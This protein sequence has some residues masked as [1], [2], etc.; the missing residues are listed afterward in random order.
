MADL[1]FP[2]PASH[3]DS[4][5]LNG[6]KYVYD[7]SANAWLTVLL[8]APLDTGNTSNTQI[9]FNDAGVANGSYGLTFDRQANTFR[10]NTAVISGNV[11][12]SFYN[13]DGSALTNLNLS[14]IYTLTNAAFNSANDTAN[15]SAGIA[16][17]LV[18]SNGDLLTQIYINSNTLVQEITNAIYVIANTAGNTAN[19]A[20]QVANTAGDTAND[21]GQVANTSGNTSNYAGVVANAASVVS[22]TAANTANYAGTVANASGQVSNTAG[23]TANY[24]GTV[25]NAAGLVSN[26]SG[27]TANYAGTV[28]NAS[29]QIA[30]TAGNTAN[31]A[32]TVAN[33]AGVV[34]NTAGDTANAAGQVANTSGNTANTAGTVANAAGQVANTAGNTA[35]FSYTVSNA[36]FDVANTAGVTANLAGTVANAAGQVSN[37]AGNTANYAGVV[38][39]AAGQTANVAG[40][41]ANFSYLVS[42]A[43]F[44]VANAAGVTAN[45]S[46][47]VSN[48]S[49]QVSNTAGNTA[50]Y[51]GT[52]ANAAG[53]VANTAGDTANTAGVVA[54]AAGQV[55]NTSGNTSNFAGQVAN[56]AGNTA[57]YAGTVANAS[58]GVANTAGDTANVAGTVANTAGDTANV[59][60]TVANAAGQ[61]A[62]VAAN[63]ANLAG[64]TANTYGVVANTAGNTANYAGTVANA[65]GQVANTSGNTANY[66]G[67]VANAAGVVANT[68]GDTANAA[69]LVS[70]TAG[71]T[72]NTAELIANTAGNTANYA[73][74][75]AN[76]ACNIANNYIA[77]TSNIVADL[78]IS[79]S[80]YL[81]IINV[82]TYEAT[83]TYLDGVVSTLFDRAN[84]SW[85]YVGVSGNTLTATAT[86]NTLSIANTGGIT[87]LSNT[88]NNWIEFTMN[89]TGVTAASYGSATNIP[90]LE[91][92]DDGR[93]YSASNVAVQGMD[94]PFANSVGNAANSYAAA[95]YYA[96]TGGTISGDVVVT[97]N[98]TISGCTTY[99][100]TQTLLIGDN[101]LSLNADLPVAVAPSENAGLEVNRGSS[102]NVSVLWNESQ[103]KWTFTNDGTTY[104]QI[105]SNTDVISAN[106][107]SG[108]MANA[109]NAFANTN[110]WS[111]ANASWTSVSVPGNTLNATAS[112]NT[113]YIAN[114]NDIVILSNTQNSWIQFSINTSGVIAQ[115]YGS[116]TNI[117]VLTISDDGRISYAANV[118][119]Q[120]MDYPFAN[121]KL[122][123]TDGMT[124]AGS[125]YFPTTAKLGIGTNNPAANLDVVGSFNVSKANVLSQT[126]SDSS[127]TINWDIASGAVA[128]VTLTAAGRTLANPTNLRVGTYILHVLQDGSGSRTI[129]SWGTAYKFPA[130]VKPTFSTAASSHDI[131]SF[132]CDGTN[133]YGSY[134]IGVA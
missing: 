79:N 52:V 11:T 46:Y 127:G 110:I 130:G 28:A 131:L 89:A 90:V 24:A 80:Y 112:A 13:G 61:T 7:S 34:A 104:V 47:T 38:A 27:N 76:N 77:N 64:S 93:I 103:D 40:N 107:Y 116:A 49:F 69:G 98:L 85:T 16:A 73:G 94:Y 124:F 14:S 75:V 106:A 121:T 134:L 19:Y 29:N 62:N 54:N 33:A 2:Y 70:N 21:A 36:A 82:T 71:D 119:V 125:L 100:N 65:A 81:G 18:T 42:N 58:F 92:G 41:T 66:A 132:V 68:A 96:K 22:N 108:S 8:Q 133:L 60:G 39:N 128:T 115:T 12:A 95:T 35:N 109:V 91:V 32:G 51:A 23:N 45:Y 111:R 31:Y 84:A 83:N 5:S 15:I 67:T 86:S 102:T 129:T 126:L 50:N 99:A 88:Q 6:V 30:N 123:N 1:N 3:G 72:A 9:V 105:A 63:T 113:L 37:T 4:Y 117:P 44:D 53:L 59:A 56:T 74:E 57:N 87:V 97:G 122:S 118:A 78:M 101:I 25:A 120:G 26:T 55:A 10:T 20:G 114:S 48:A 17:N 43:A